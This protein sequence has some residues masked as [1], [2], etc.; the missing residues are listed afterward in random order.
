M[1]LFHF[2]DKYPTQSNGEV[3]LIKALQLCQ[4][5]ELPNNFQ[6]RIQE[7]VFDLKVFH[8]HLHMIDSVHIQNLNMPY[9]R[10]TLSKTVV[11]SPNMMYFDP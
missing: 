10:R 9:L 4:K 1:F 2:I 3:R 11:L 6:E 8:Y 5:K 7:I